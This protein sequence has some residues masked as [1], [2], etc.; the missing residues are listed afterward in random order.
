MKTDDI[1]I[2]P[3]KLV[4]EIDAISSKSFAHRAL[5][6]AALSNNPTNIYINEFSKDINVTIDGLKNL[7]VGIEKNEDF[8]K[9]M[10]PKE[11]IDQATIDMYESG[12]SLRFF[13][14][15]SSHFSKNTKIIG[16]KRLAQRPNLELINNLRK[17]GLEISADKIPYTIKGELKVGQFEFLENKSSQYITAIM[18]AASKLKGKT[19]IKLSE[20]PESIGYIDITRKVL[21][22]FN[23][24]VKKDKH[25]YIIENPE[26]KSPKN[27][28]VEGDWSNAAFFYGAN[29]LG[30]K[31]EISNLDKNS[32]QKDREI[33][34]ICQKIK[35]CKEEN[36][37]LKIDISQIPDLCPIVA[38]LL[39]YLDKT[40]Y[41]INGERL[42]LKE[43]DR[44][45]S[46][47]K[48]L[49]DLRANCQI[50]GDG[51]KISG[52]ISGGK[53]DSYNDHRI[54]M[55]ASIGSLLAKEDII[56]RNYKAVNKSYPSFFKTFEKLGGRIKYLGA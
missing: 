7:G 1:L 26:I 54:V 15:V 50:L 45:E 41:I 37:E 18:L 35:K 55:A 22:D 13:T 16:E 5:I 10:P 23:V 9:I 42:R 44:L 21:K 40:S 39:T 28:I 12:S 51:L 6:M 4:G 29:L 14:G 46:T 34:E 8:V 31:I 53:V 52:K 36:K 11:K 43:S 19:Y 20:K 25:S 24:D 32:L 2:H 38:I 48:M 30:S 3:S 47:S 56:I 49:N 17:H 27:Y 33:V